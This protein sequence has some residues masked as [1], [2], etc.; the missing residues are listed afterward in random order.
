MEH[1][2]RKIMITIRD[3]AILYGESEDQLRI[4]LD[5]AEERLTDSK[6]KSEVIKY[7]SGKEKE[8]Q[9]DWIYEVLD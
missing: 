2:D 5:E 6:F 8:Y 3:I 7:R 4:R 1:S 9:I